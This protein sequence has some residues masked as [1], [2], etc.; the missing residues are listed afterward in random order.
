LCA[1][2]TD[3]RFILLVIRFV[4]RASGFLY[5]FSTY[6]FGVGLWYHNVA[7]AVAGGIVLAISFM[8]CLVDV[9]LGHEEPAVDIRA[10]TPFA[11]AEDITRMKLN[12]V[13]FTKSADGTWTAVR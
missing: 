9:R 6:F 10:R 13:E 1:K 3:M 12:D 11:S 7:M 2:V 4:L 5:G 8:A